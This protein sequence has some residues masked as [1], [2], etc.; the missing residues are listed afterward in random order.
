MY[1]LLLMFVHNYGCYL[2]MDPS[3]VFRD[4]IICSLRTGES[5][6]FDGP[7]ICGLRGTRTLLIHG[8]G[9]HF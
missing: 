9:C 2:D 4:F 5:V 6:D 8:R 7:L 3:I 1:A